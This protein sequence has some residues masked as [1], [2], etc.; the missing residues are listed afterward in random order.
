MKCVL[1]SIAAHKAD[2]LARMASRNAER[3]INPQGK[4]AELSVRRR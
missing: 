3:R 2:K 1:A 4:R